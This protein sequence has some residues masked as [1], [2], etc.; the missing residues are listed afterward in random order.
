M[1]TI[2]GQ[3]ISGLIAIAP[4]HVFH[5][6]TPDVTRKEIKDTDTEVSRFI[7]ARDTAS[8]IMQKL[9]D[10]A[11]STSGADNAA[12]FENYR[13]LLAAPEFTN[14]TTGIIRS[15]KVN[16]EYAVK[17]VEENYRQILASDN[18]AYASSSMADFSVVVNAVIEALQSGVQ[19]DTLTGPCILASHDLTPEQ[20]I[21]FDKSKLL[22][23]VTVDGNSLSHTA[24]LARSLGVPAILATGHEIG[25]ELTGHPAIIDGFTGTVYVDP[26]PEIIQEMKQKQADHKAQRELLEEL[27]GLPAETEDGRRVELSA[28]ISSAGDLAAVIKNDAESIGLFR[29]EFIYMGRDTLPTE[30]EQFK[31][32]KLAAETMAGKRVIIR[33]VDIGNDKQAS[34]F[35]L[36]KEVNPALGMRAIR[37]SLTRPDIFKTQLRAIL[38]ASAFGRIAIMFPLITSVWEVWKAKEI[39]ENVKTELDKNQIPYDHH[40]EVGI[41]VETPAAAL[42]SDKLAKEVDF[43]SIGTNDLSQY[44]LVVDRNIQD[45]SQFFN[46]HHPAVLKLIRMTIENAHANHIWVGI[47]GELGAD[48]TLTREF[49]EMGVDELSVAPYDILP[50]RKKVRSLNLSEK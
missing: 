22:G 21:R 12:I 49:L 28:N 14:Q 34:A 4:L 42:I 16:F 23:F 37:V 3:S 7:T 27:R 43:F 24:I 46:P 32:Y 11:L 29:S 15:Q 33:T 36:P 5:P 9:H 19:R 18:A 10:Q 6:F 25:D 2:K 45:S 39:L 26:T 47:C 38:R 31:I 30:E 48:L 20:T 40:L 41:M 44:T 17:Q 35:G 50:L 8:T 1:L 13:Q